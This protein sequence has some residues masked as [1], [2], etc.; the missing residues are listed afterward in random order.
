MCQ[1]DKLVRHSS[2]AIDIVMMFCQLRDFWRFLQWPKQHSIPLLSQLLDCICSSAVLYTDIVYKQLQETGFFER[3]G[4]FQTADDMCIAA[5]NLEYIAKFISLLGKIYQQLYQ[6]II[7]EYIF[8]FL[9]NY[10]DFITLET[11]TTEAQY[12]NL[13]NLLDSTLNHLQSHIKNILRIVRIQMQDSLRKTIF[14]L[15]WSP[16]SLPTAQAIDPLFDYLHV[17][18]QALNMALFPQNFQ[19]VLFE[20]S[21]CLCR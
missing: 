15:A 5:N 21:C 13:T 1:G 20:V 10:F 2:S 11:I 6:Y 14:H 7:S 4:P 9:E 8:Y 18:L 17:H 19:R 16:D 12:A 3:V